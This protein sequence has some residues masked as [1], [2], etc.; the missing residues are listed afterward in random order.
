MQI[1][2]HSDNH[3]EGSARL[4][5]W[6]SASVAGKLDRFDDELTRVVVHLN[7]ENGDKAGAHDKRCQIEARPK[8]LQP[9]SVT[10]KAESLEL[11]VDGAV[12]KLNNAL[13][14]QFGK[15]RSKRAGGQ[16]QMIDGAAVAG[17]DALLEEDF[18]ADEQVRNS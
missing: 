9:I 6:V 5:D 10:H 14:H 7:D 15:L 1:Q 18:L 17:R 13:A 8:G 12:D 2:V 4:A 3:I 11:A 16:P